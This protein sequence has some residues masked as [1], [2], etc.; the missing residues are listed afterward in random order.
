MKDERCHPAVIKVFLVIMQDWTCIGGYL[1]SDEMNH[2]RYNSNSSIHVQK[3]FSRFNTSDWR[4]FGWC[5]NIYKIFEWLNWIIL[6]F[7]QY[8]LHLEIKLLWDV[9]ENIRNNRRSVR[10]IIWARMGMYK[11]NMTC[12]LSLSGIAVWV[13]EERMDLENIEYPF[14]C[15]R[16]HATNGCEMMIWNL[17]TGPW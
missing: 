3:L 12:N 8:L 6:I 4:H 2:L 5:T 9:S 1:S 13:D 16:C 10:K 7:Q 11:K 14:H 15:V 17:V